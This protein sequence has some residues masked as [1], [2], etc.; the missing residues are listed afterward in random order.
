LAASVFFTSAQAEDCGPL[1]KLFSL[2]LTS[3]PSGVSSVSVII[4]GSPRRLE[5]DT[6][7]GRSILSEGALD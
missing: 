6:A 1:K 3:S 2:D 7:G 4:N 5:F